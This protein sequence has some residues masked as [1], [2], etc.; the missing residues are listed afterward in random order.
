MPEATLTDATHRVG[1]PDPA[2]KMRR[3]QTVGTT[4]IDVDLVKR[5][6]NE[7]IMAHACFDTSTE[8]DDTAVWKRKK[9]AH[10]PAEL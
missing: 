9:T 5:M 10:D 7:T 3:V 4:E 1:E 6:Y 8:A 2:K